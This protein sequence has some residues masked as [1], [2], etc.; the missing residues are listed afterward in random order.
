[1]ITDDIC[2][3]ICSEIFL[4]LPEF[5]LNSRKNSTRTWKLV[6][7]HIHR[8]VRLN[9]LCAW[10]WAAFENSF[11]QTLTATG[12][13]A[14]RRKWIMIA[15]GMHD[16]EDKYAVTWHSLSP[17][18]GVN[19]ERIFRRLIYIAHVHTHARKATTRYI[20]STC[21]YSH[22]YCKT[23]RKQAILYSNE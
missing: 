2:A 6:W 13:V 19:V 15:A 12:C 8:T 14:R 17:R 22:K 21:L 23:A 20:C 11:Q 4:L 16:D 10:T 18:T 1:M 7:K 9:A 3:V 5:F